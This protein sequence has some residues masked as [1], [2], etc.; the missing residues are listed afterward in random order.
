MER[1]MEVL[2]PTSGRGED[3]A[4]GFP[5]D[6][7]TGE[8]RRFRLGFSL[9]HLPHTGRQDDWEFGSAT[10]GHAGDAGGE[11]SRTADVDDLADGDPRH[12]VA[13]GLTSSGAGADG[14]HHPPP[15]PMESYRWDGEAWEEAAAKAKKKAMLAD[16]GPR[17]AVNMP[18]HLQALFPSRS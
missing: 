13:T 12:S 4:C 8:T 3:R 5:D 6:P 17:L 7:A 9:A 14:D 18:G 11:V 2:C 1:P 16:S 10:S 15:I